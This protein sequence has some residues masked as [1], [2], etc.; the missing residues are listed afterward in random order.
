MD[1]QSTKRWTCRGMNGWM[2]DKMMVVELDGKRDSQKNKWI[3]GY[4]NMWLGNQLDHGWK[5]A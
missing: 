2:I 1:N 4:M 5:D 3:H